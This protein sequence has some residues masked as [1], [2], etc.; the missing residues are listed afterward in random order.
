[1]IENL[2]LLNTLTSTG[3]RRIATW[4]THSAQN[5]NRLKG[6]SRHF[7][8]MHLDEIS[9]VCMELMRCSHNVLL[10]SFADNSCRRNKA[11]APRRL[12]YPGSS[13]AGF[14]AGIYDW[15]ARHLKRT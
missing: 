6:I 9:C 7:V 5:I 2:G 11:F 15:A 10:T 14:N 12:R 3:S 13:V 8:S 1:M 4:I